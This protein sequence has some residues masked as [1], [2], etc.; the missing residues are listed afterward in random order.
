MLL[1]QNTLF[2]FLAIVIEFCYNYFV[3]LRTQ[4]TYIYIF[5]PPLFCIILSQT[6]TPAEFW[7][8]AF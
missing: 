3:R 8:N 4:L 2:F 7:Q 5:F 6:E 1:G